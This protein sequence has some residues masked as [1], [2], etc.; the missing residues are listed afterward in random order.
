MLISKVVPLHFL[1]GLFSLS[2]EHSVHV[3]WME[4]THALPFNKELKDGFHYSFFLGKRVSMKNLLLRSRRR[5]F[6]LI[7]LLVVIAII[8]ILIGLLLPAIQ[9]VREAAARTKSLNN[10]SQLGKAFH[11]HQD[12]AGALPYNGVNA[13]AAAAGTGFTGSWA[14]QICPFI[15]QNNFYNNG[16]SAI[17]IP[18][19]VC[20]GRGRTGKNAS[21]PTTDYAINANVNS[22]SGVDQANNMVRIENIVDGASNTIFAGT[23]WMPKADYTSSSAYGDGHIGIGGGIGTGRALL[24]YAQDGGSGSLNTA[25]W[26]GSF[27]A[28][29]LFMFGDGA[30]RVVPY[31]AGDTSAANL[32]GGFSLM[33]RY[34]QT[35]DN[36]TVS[37][38]N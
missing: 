28:G 29:G 35:N 36:Q 4:S 22:A 30:A 19:F 13:T 34:L 16:V 8:A 12:A 37:F 24:T 25:Q 5:A 32:V 17:S 9:K 14:F 6:T 20:P 26:G 3:R 27:P 11:L 18:I 15:E 38:P 23:K 1:Q 2:L 33:S 31:S 10:L 21:G 7:E